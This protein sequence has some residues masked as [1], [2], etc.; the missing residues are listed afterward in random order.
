MEKKITLVEALS[1][2]QFSFTH[3]DGKQYL[4][5]SEKGDVLRPGDVRALHSLGMPVY[6]K[7]F[8]KGTLFIQF[9]VEFPKQHFLKSDKQSGTLSEILGQTPAPVKANGEMEP[10]TLAFVNMK[11]HQQQQQRQAYEQDDD[12]EEGHGHGGP[13]GVPCTQ[14]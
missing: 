8:E 5:K 10:V 11:Q 3:L 1:G 6:K 14:Q 4:V 13:R 7:S 12:D 2:F 9:D